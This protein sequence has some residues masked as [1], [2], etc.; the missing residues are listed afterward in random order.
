M[1]KTALS[2]VPFLFVKM[3]VWILKASSENSVAMND[4]AWLNNKLLF[5][6]KKKK[7]VAHHPFFPPMLL[8][9]SFLK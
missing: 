6:E 5:I 7:V 2:L 3:I 8:K 1:S 9:N 4:Y